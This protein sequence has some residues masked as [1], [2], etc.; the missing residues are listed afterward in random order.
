[1]AFPSCDRSLP[2]APYLVHAGVR[3]VC[4]ASTF[5]VSFFHAA[6]FQRTCVRSS[7]REK[8]RQHRCLIF[9]G[10]VS[11]PT[12]IT[13]GLRVLEMGSVVVCMVVCVSLQAEKGQF[14]VKKAR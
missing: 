3:A 10:R 1:M 6:H 8:A 2:L 9:V 11:H 13:A 12:S 7:P 5:G 4:E 14:S